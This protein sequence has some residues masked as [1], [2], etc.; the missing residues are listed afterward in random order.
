MGN[1]LTNKNTLKTVYH[2]ECYRDGK[3]IW[4][5][6]FENLVV[7]TGLNAIISNTFKTIPGSV[8]W[9][10][11]L[12]GAGTVNAAD[13]PGSHAGWSELTIYSNSTRPA[14]TAGT[15]SGGSV[16]NSASKA[17]FNINGSG[18]V[19]G[20]AMFDNNTKGGTSGTLYGAGDF[21]AARD[22]LSGDTLNVTV[23]LSATSS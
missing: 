5:D 3:L 8:S 1:I 13:T 12:K 10:V 17:V 18:T 22:V 9:F 7:T 15:V 16:D 4:E 14:F 23:T 20:A 21:A 6:S 2:V 19:A 11:G